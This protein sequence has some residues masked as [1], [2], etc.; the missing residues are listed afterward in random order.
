M[1]Y[2]RRLDSSAKLVE[3]S[4]KMMKEVSPE[5]VSHEARD[6]QCPQSLIFE[7]NRAGAMESSSCGAPRKPM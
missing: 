6:T 5:M 3:I 2:H 4:F 7:C 1:L